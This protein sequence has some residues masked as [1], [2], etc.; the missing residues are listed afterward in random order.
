MSICCNGGTAEDPCPCQLSQSKLDMAKVDILMYICTTPDCGHS[1]G[2]HIPGVAPVPG[3]I[4][5]RW[6]ISSLGMDVLFLMLRFTEVI[7]IYSS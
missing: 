2:L 3:N 4:H 6:Q 7:K 1:Y 5:P